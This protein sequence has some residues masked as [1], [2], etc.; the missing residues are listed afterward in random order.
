[1][2][3][4]HCVKGEIHNVLTALRLQTSDGVRLSRRDSRMCDAALSALTPP[5]F[6]PS[7]LP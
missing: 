6:P 4:V 5:L 3:G 2:Q 1:M 7:L